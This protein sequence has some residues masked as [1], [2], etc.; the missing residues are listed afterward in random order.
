MVATA[1]ND[2][3]QTRTAWIILI[4]LCAFLFFDFIQINMMNSMGPFLLDTFNLTPTQLGVVSSLFF[5]VNLIFLFPAG[6]L[7]D[8]Y[9]PKWLV[10]SS[11]LV[12]CLGILIF[13]IHPNKNTMMAWRALSGIGGAFSYLSCVKI[14]AS[15]FPRKILG[16]FLGLTGIVIMSAGV[17]AQ[18]PLIFLLR[19]YGI[20]HT[21]WADIALAAVII[22]LMLTMINDRR[23]H[24]KKATFKF[25]I[26][27]AHKQLKNWII[28]LYAS[29]T[30]FPLFVLGALWG[31]LYLKN[32]HGFHLAVAAFISSMIFVGNMFGAPILGF[33]SDRLKSRAGLMMM[34][35]IIY[36]L[37]I[38]AIM[39]APTNSSH[40]LFLILF[41]ILGF[42]TG[43]QTLAYA[44]AVD[45]NRSEQVAKATSLLS[46]LSVGGGALAQPLFGWLAGHGTLTHYQHGMY[47]LLI[48]ALIAIYLAWLFRKLR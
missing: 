17:A 21:L 27:Q 24:A 7:L 16:L 29:L 39:A 30:N 28:A 25:K 43:S 47:I 12:T 5:Y 40:T 48:A 15:F 4:P 45:A 31:D 37:S 22:I 33:I 36:L 23:S 44:A 41:F 18:Y 6:M 3:N 1:S 42:S 10:I 9:S 26:S 2:A 32:Q 13:I 19:E 46:I 14:L 8:A 34:S 11:I 35:A 38:I 20:S